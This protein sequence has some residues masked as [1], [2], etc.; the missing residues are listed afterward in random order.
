MLFIWFEGIRVWKK[1]ILPWRW[2]NRCLN[3]AKKEAE[4]DKNMQRGEWKERRN[5]TTNVHFLKTLKVMN[6]A[7]EI[8]LLS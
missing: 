8:I 4:E 3:R 2:E 5:K 7:N 1:C 6:N